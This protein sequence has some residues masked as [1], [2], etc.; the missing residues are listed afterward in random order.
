MTAFSNENVKAWVKTAI[1]LI[2]GHGTRLRPL[3]ITT[4]KPMLHLCNRPIVEF[5]LDQFVQVGVTR[6]ILACCNNAESVQ[7][8]EEI[9]IIKENVS[10]KGMTQVEIILSVEKSP[11]G[12]AGPIKLA[13]KYLLEDDHFFVMNSDIIAELPLV[14][15]INEYKSHETIGT[16][17]MAKVEDPTRFGV[18]TSTQ[19]INLNVESVELNGFVE[20]PSTFISNWINGGVY[21]FK[22]SFLDYIPQG[23]PCSLEREIFPL[24]LNSTDIIRG[25]PI[26]TYWKDVGKPM[27]F[28]KGQSLILTH[29]GPLKDVDGENRFITEEMAKELGIE[30]EGQVFVHKDAKIEPGS[31]LGPNV[32]IGKSC[33]IESCCRIR[34]CCIMEG[35]NVK[36]GSVILESI[37]AKDCQIGAWSRLIKGSIIANDVVIESETM[38]NGSMVLPNIVVRDDLS[39]SG[40]IILF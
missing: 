39:S 36:K 6:F 27:D 18:L 9:D 1:L 24:I 8:K 13:E 12:T 14:K 22:K 11:L 20:K 16:I 19:E 40:E 31:K 33:I 10:K 28:L 5:L 2:G 15:M 26:H 3:T 32:A 35:T 34:E 4:P 25:V 37:I 23:R 21:L 29:K 30:I 7:L 17:M 38:L